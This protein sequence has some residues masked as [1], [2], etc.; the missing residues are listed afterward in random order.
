ML[1]PKPQSLS[2]PLSTMFSQTELAEKNF[3]YH[4]RTVGLIKC[5]CVTYT[6]ILDSVVWLLIACTREFKILV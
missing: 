3:P 5:Y 2:N 1:L 6:Q 4:K